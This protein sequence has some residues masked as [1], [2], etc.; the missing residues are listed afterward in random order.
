MEHIAPHLIAVLNSYSLT[1][2]SEKFQKLFSDSF[3]TFKNRYIGASADFSYFLI[4][5]IVERM[6]QK[7]LPLFLGAKRQ[8]RQDFPAGFHTTHIL[9]RRFTVGQPAL[10]NNYVL[11]IASL[12]PMVFPLTVKAPV[13]LLGNRPKLVKGGGIFIGQIAPMLSDGN[14][15]PA[16]SFRSDFSGV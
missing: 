13:K 10:G 8:Y 5:K 14:S 6:E 9:L 3:D 4:A 16:F 2:L 11:V 1:H 7:P 15:H 12:V